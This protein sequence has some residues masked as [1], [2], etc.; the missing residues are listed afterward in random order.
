M[1]PRPQLNM[2]VAQQNALAKAFARHREEATHSL[3][4]RLADLEAECAA[5]RKQ[6]VEL[7]S[8]IP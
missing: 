5:L 2:R 4:A 6:I 8:E 3:R 1:M 7:N